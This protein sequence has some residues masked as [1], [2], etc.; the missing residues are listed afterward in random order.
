MA[1]TQAVNP[2]TCHTHPSAEFQPRYYNERVLEAAKK[3]Q[4]IAQAA[5]ISLAQLSL[6]WAGSRWYMG[7]VIIGATTMQQ[8]RYAS[9]YT[10]G[11][12]VWGGSAV[13]YGWQA[14]A[15]SML[16]GTHKALAWPLSHPSGAV[17][18]HCTLAK[19]PPPDLQPACPGRH[20]PVLQLKENIDAFEAVQLSEETLKAIEEVHKV[21]RNPQASD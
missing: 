19:A 8:V 16:H 2:R 1:V 20:T 6:A 17:S 21:H 18:L 11:G 14:E 13:L 10:V 3:Y 9:Q 4:A 15:A 5:G 12:A 7:S